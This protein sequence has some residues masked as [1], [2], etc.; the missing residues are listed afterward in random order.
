[1]EF[2]INWHKKRL[3]WCF[4]SIEKSLCNFH[5]EKILYGLWRQ[6]IG[7]CFVYN[8]FFYFVTFSKTKYFRIHYIQTMITFKILIF[9]QT[10]YYILAIIIGEI[11]ISWEKFSQEWFPVAEWGVFSEEKI[12]QTEGELNPESARLE[13]LYV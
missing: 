13:V 11:I 1:M 3:I 4:C 6:G 12:F 5:W 10:P 8:V 2:Y 9:M 7:S